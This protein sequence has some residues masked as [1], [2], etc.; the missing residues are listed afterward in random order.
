MDVFILIKTGLLFSVIFLITVGFFISPTV[1]AQSDNDLEKEQLQLEKERRI[2]D[3]TYQNL[4]QKINSLTAT[5]SQLQSSGV[6]DDKLE[7]IEEQLEE[8][9]EELSDLQ[10]SEPALL[11]QEK[12]FK[13][14]SPPL[15]NVQ[16]FEESESIPSWF[17]NNAKWWKEGLISDGD[18]INAL[19]SL[20][21]QDI[22]PLD[23]FI[24]TS[25]N[26]AIPQSMG[27]PITRSAIDGAA[28][29]DKS[30]YIAS[31][32]YGTPKEYAIP[33][34]QKDVFGFW[35]D[36][37]VADSEIVNSIGHLMSEGI[38]NSEKIQ[39]EISER[40]IKFDQKM[41]EL[42][43]GLDSK[44]SFID[45][46][47][48]EHGSKTVINPDGSKTITFPDK[49]YTI[50]F[51]DGSRVT[52]FPN[53]YDYEDSNR[54]YFASF[55]V[56]EKE[57]R[58]SKVI[59]DADGFRTFYQDENVVG[60]IS[61]NGDVVRFDYSLRSYDNFDTDNS[62]GGMQQLS[63]TTALI[64]DNIQFPISQFALWKWTGECDDAWHYHTPTSQAISIDGLTG[65]LDPDQENCG[66]GKVG[67]VQITTT[68]MSQD[69]I[70]KFRELTDSDPLENEAMMGG[71]DTGSN[72]VEDGPNNGNNSG[73]DDTGL[74]SLDESDDLP[75]GTSEVSDDA[76][77]AFIDSDG[78]GIDDAIDAEPNKVSDELTTDNGEGLHAKILERNGNTIKITSGAEGVLVI[79]VGGYDWDGSKSVI[80]EILGIELELEPGTIIEVSFF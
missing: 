9:R 6:T 50:F 29:V 72:S 68:F 16:V 26:S 17:K 21:I 77:G 31:P 61:S 54:I 79:E 20:I 18:I 45:N 27:G 78:D 2:Y 30:A 33:S 74:T 70:D 80:V 66:F 56:A 4:Q 36:G 15:P 43:A 1:F 8:L 71:S 32:N 37:Q 41:A 76:F 46:P 23:N 47:D 57:F 11:E 28:P 58:A 10:E 52:H 42:D 38:I 12:S 69:E 65:I 48:L 64:I 63:Q 7:D 22:I 3:E 25:S 60:L 35:S 67:E 40:Q 55:P 14:K 13:E 73:G 62:D 53:G 19:E 24:K 49:S 5:L 34:Y 44:S 51:E 75:F 39:T 59:T